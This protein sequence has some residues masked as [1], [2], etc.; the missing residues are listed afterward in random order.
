MCSVQ[1]S[2]VA[3]VS[4]VGTGKTWGENGEF[5][6]ESFE[7]GEFVGEAEGPEMDLEDTLPAGNVWPVDSDVSIESARAQESGVQ[8]IGS[9]STCKDNDMLSCTKTIH[10]DQELVQRKLSLIVPPHA[11]ALSS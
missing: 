4:D 2:L 5:V 3:H 7:L 11:V 9:I 10:L 8:D 1:G 6:G